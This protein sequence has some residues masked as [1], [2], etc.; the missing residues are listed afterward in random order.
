MSSLKGLLAR[1]RSIAEPRS[2]ESRME[3][4]FRFHVEME[5]QRLVEQYELSPD[6][7]RRRALV[8]F[9][10][11]DTHR[12][13][14]RDGR[15]ARWFDD[16]FADV[17]YAVRAMRRSPGFAS[18]V[19]LTLGLGIGVNGI[20][21]GYVDSLLFRRVP[22]RDADNLVSM[23]TVDTETKQ[24]NQVAYE[25]YLDFRNTS[26]VFDGLAG[27]AGI[28]LNVAMPGRASA[29]DMVWG[30]IVT[31]NFFSVLGMTP[32]LGR[33]FSPSDAARGENALAV[34]S[35]DGWMRRFGGDSSVVGRTIRINGTVFTIVGVAARGFRGM[36]TFGFWPE[37]WVPIGMHDV[38]W[39]GSVHLL[40]GRGPGWMM[41]VGRMRRGVDRA[42]TETAARR[43]ARQL[44]QAYP[45]TNASTDVM[46][47]PAAIGFDHPAFVKPK[48]IVL[49]SA[50]GVFASLVTLIIICAN[51]INLQLAR[52]GARA[53]ELAIR[54]SLGCSRA[55]LTRQ[56]VVE[57][58]VLA[59]PGAVIAIGLLK[60]GTIIESYMV[61]HLQFRVGLTS[62]VDLRVA[63]FTAAVALFAI[64]LL[65]L[66]PALRASRNPSLAILIGAKRT[67]AGR[68]QSLRGVLVVSQLSLSVVLLVG[69][70]LFVRSMLVARATDLG[71]DA[72]HRAVMS[73][74]VGLQGY[75]TTRGRR[76]YDDVLARVRGM[77]AVASAAWMF[78]VPFDTYGRSVSLYVEGVSTR[79]KDGTITLNTSVTSED[80][81]NALGLRLESGRDFGL[82]DSTGAPPVMVI[83]RQAATRL[84]PGMNPIGQRAR[85]G[86]A[87]GPEVTVV[88][89][90]DDAK[91]ESLGPSSVAR[92]YMPLRQRY[93][94]WQT[95]V[96]HTRGDPAAA[97]AQL[98][99]SVS[100]V[101]PV[102]PV[103]GATTMEQGVESGLSTSRTA[104]SVAGFFG[105]LAVLISSVGLYAVVASRVAE[106]TR[107]LGVR[108]AL[109]STPSDVMWLVMRGG[110]R[111]GLLG[112][113]IGLG[114]SVVV[115]RLMSALLY[116]MSPAD[117]FT[118]VFVPL[119]LA[120]VVLVAT[121]IPARRAVRLDP[122]VALRNE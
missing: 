7:A 56:M 117:P 22:A 39:P 74:N 3:E 18:A 21:F 99:S 120:V 30:E 43:F 37:I 121:Y 8:A 92:V 58:A 33:L 63:L 54:L 90:V 68:R 67:S 34:L 85:R 112:L 88:G 106:R 49:A 2:S 28:P 107:E 71:F 25:D 103:F 76:F 64:L 41:T 44:A 17:R 5:T 61:P 69:A 13:T 83:S 93:R 105:A 15:G 31:E 53:S 60:T 65:G 104:A 86:G 89:V 77:P 23:F 122:M 72:T 78:P 66:V 24:P 79:S 73:V 94:D 113:A 110:A 82:G 52:A 32:A 20:V 98:K 36:R 97:I 6:E 12:E 35:H 119:T 27:M 108:M 42:Q 57:S 87:K 29:S 102:L 26:G 116:G 101:D 45:A 38:A 48:I 50:L 115:A 16:L 10:G 9:G 100:A 91:F 19:A 4:E 55:R 95:L 11:L 40:E 118:F 1:T 109:G 46:I 111:L 51:L 59:V 80:F 75:D 84:W 114:G 14:M 47:I 62:G 70:M 81:V 96:V